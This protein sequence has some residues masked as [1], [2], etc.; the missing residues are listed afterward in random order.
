MSDWEDICQRCGQCCFEKWIDEDGHVTVTTLS[1][2]FLDVVERTCKVYHKRF[3][4]GEGCVRLTPEV[5]AA[6]D[7]LPSDCAYRHYVKR[8]NP[9]NSGPEEKP[10]DFTTLSKGAH[11]K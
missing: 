3:D 6:A 8:L 4:V 10:G 1:C 11:K 9:S 7:W 2:R 5:V